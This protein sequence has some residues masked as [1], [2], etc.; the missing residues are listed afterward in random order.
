MPT[1]HRR[2]RATLTLGLCM[3]GAFLFVG[4]RPTVAD[5]HPS[6]LVCELSDGQNWFIVV[7]NFGGIG[8]AVHHCITDLSGHPTGLQE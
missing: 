1:P 3:L 5:A 2:R 7:E 6:F 8:R 4:A